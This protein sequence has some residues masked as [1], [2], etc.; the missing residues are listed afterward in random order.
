MSRDISP[1][2]SANPGSC[3][4]LFNVRVS[5]STQ[6]HPSRSYKSVSPL[7]R[8]QDSAVTDSNLSMYDPESD[9]CLSCPRIPPSF[10]KSP[11]FLS[12]SPKSF[13]DHF[14]PSHYHEPFPSPSHYHEP[15]P[16]PSHFHEPFPSPSHFH[17]PFPSPSHHGS[18]PHNRREGAGRN[19]ASISPL[20]SQSYS[21][22]VDL[23]EPFVVASLQEAMPAE[24][25]DEPPDGKGWRRRSPCALPNSRSLLRKETHEEK[26]AE[27]ET[28]SE[29]NPT[30]GVC[31]GVR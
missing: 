3:S 27:L 18:L 1:A 14:S 6:A 9:T 20:H 12:K 21:R 19:S 2:V 8:L 28:N 23:Q 15:F 11:K 22:R 17:E 31:C 5:D 30:T 24:E 4:S 29:A 25:A 7:H 10:S 26:P 16:S 13:V